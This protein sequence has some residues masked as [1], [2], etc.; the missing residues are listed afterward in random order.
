[1]IVVTGATGTIGSGVVRELASRGAEV[2]AFVR[3]RAKAERMLGAG[4]PLAVGDFADP[5]TIRAAVRSAHT[6]VLSSGNDPRQ[7]EYEAA[8]VDAVV[9]TGGRRVVKISSVGA[10]APSSAT[11]VDSHHRSEQHLARSGLPASTIRCNFF[12][13]NLFASA[14]MIRQ[15]GQI[16][17]PAGNATIAM[18]DP[19]DVAAA[20]AAVVTDSAN[21]APA[22]ELTGPEPLTYEQVADTLS[23]VLGRRITFVDMPDGVAKATVVGSG[24]PEWFADGFVSLFE[25]LRQG[26]AA[27]TSDRVRILTGRDPRSLGEF[28]QDHAGLFSSEDA[29]VH[30]TR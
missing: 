11:F 17:A 6:V 12:M 2:R 19:R 3:D 5:A 15:M 22:Y 30:A 7:A 23:E 9:A 20:V 25:V 4:V 28:V 21:D 13:S 26:I 16:G 1:M 8:V 24:L 10:Q 14:A 27:A 29:A 18:V